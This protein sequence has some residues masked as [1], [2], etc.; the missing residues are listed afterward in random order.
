VVTAI[1]SRPLM[2]ASPTLA[3][4]PIGSGADAERWRQWQLA[5]AIG[6]RKAAGGARV[7]F[8]VLFTASIGWVGWL[9]S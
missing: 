7:V 2:N 4:E 8:A 9:L 5:N 3:S 6:D 1:T